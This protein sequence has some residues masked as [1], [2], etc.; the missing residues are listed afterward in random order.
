LEEGKSVQTP[1]EPAC[2][3][4]LTKAIDFPSDEQ[5][6]WWRKSAPLLARILESADYDLHQQYQFLTLYNTL[7]VPNMGSFPHIWHASITHSGIPVEFSVNYQDKE[8]HTVRVGFEPASFISGAA[9]DP[10]N[11]ITVTDVVCKMSRLDFHDFDSQ[12]FHQFLGPLTLSK[13]EAC[14]LQGAKLP[15]SNFKTQAAFGLDLKGIDVTV[16][17]YIYPALKAHVTGKTFRQLLEDAVCRVEDSM[18][19]FEAIRKVNDY[20]EERMYYNQYSFIGFDCTTPSRSRLKV[21]GAILN[22]SWEKV[23]EIWTLGGLLQANEDNKSGLSL[24]RSL[25]EYL[26]P[27][28]VR[29][30]P[31]SP[32]VFLR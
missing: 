7:M 23:E 14:F 15:G 31:V 32:H 21:Y 16:K 29:V 5:E 13:E 22:I 1:S 24:L 20:M 3:A 27:G 26:T 18:N 30:P 2:Y 28:K 4:S 6:L 17:C 8:R 10:Y 11:L 25:W 12:L 19:C 9:R